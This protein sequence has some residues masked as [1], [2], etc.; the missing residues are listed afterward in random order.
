M[1]QN[2]PNYTREGIRKCNSNRKAQEERAR[3]SRDSLKEYFAFDTPCLKL[4]KAKAGRFVSYRNQKTKEKPLFGGIPP[5]T[6]H[7]SVQMSRNRGYEIAAETEKEGA[8]IPNGHQLLFT[9]C[10][11]DAE[12]GIEGNDFLV[13]I[14]AEVFGRELDSVGRL[15][16]IHIDL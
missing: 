1:P 6:Y 9:M 2:L 7:F 4:T 12:C 14:A 13:A 3:G 11:S 10:F 15:V 5:A 16:G 8:G